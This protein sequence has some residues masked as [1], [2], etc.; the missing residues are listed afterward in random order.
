MWVQVAEAEG[1]YYFEPDAVRRSFL[2]A[3]EAKAYALKCLTRHRIVRIVQEL[4]VL[5]Q[6]PC[7]LDPPED[8]T[9]DHPSEV[10]I[11]DEDCA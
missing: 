4:E 9:D 10:G 7:D 11:H 6:E 1:S 8:E 3:G 2:L 5:L